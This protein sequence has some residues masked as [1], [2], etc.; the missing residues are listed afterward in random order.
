MEGAQIDDWL[1]LFDSTEEEII[2][3]KQGINEK[4]RNKKENNNKKKHGRKGRIK[5]REWTDKRTKCRELGKE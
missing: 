1:V 4:K 2:L 5:E 3:E